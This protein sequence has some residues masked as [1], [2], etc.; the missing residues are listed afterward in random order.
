M[1][2]NYEARRRGLRKLQLITDA[3]RTCPDVVI[4]LGEDL[5][6]FRDASKVLYKFLES[7]TWNKKVER[8]GFDEVFMD[9][10]DIIHYNQALLNPNDL[11]NSFFQ[12]VKDDPTQGF[13]FDATCLSGQTYPDLSSVNPSPSSDE[14]H[15]Y[16]RLI[17]GSHLACHLRHRLEE[18]KG[19]TATVGISTTK[20]VAKLV[21]NVHKPKDQTTLLPPYEKASD[22]E[23][24]E[25][26][27]TS[28]IDAHDIGKIPGIGFKR[29]HL[30]RNHILSRPAAFDEGL[31][32]GGTKENITVRDVRLFNG[33]GPELLEKI[34]GG[35]PGAEKGIG[36]KIWNLINGIDNTEV[37]DVKTVPSQISV[38]DSYIKL[39]TFPQVVN[40]L[41][42]LV[43]SL[44]KRMHMDLVEEDEEEI[45][46]K[47][48]SRTE[49]KTMRKWIAHPKTLR[50][51]TRPRPPMNPD[52]TRPRTFNRISRSAPLPSFVFNL[53]CPIETLVTK[54]INESLLPMFRKLHPEKMGWNLSL[55][56]VCVA[57]M[58]EVAGDGKA[59]V[60]DIGLM[61][62]RQEHM[63]KEWRV[64]D[65]N[66]PPDGD[67]V[68]VDDLSRENNN[69]LE[70]EDAPTIGAETNKTLLEPDTRDGHSGKGDNA[71]A[72]L[73]AGDEAI[74]S[75]D[76]PLI[77]SHR[78]FNTPTTTGS[79]DQLFLMQTQKSGSDDDEEEVTGD[80]E[81]ASEGM[82]CTICGSFMPAFA[83]VAHERFHEIVG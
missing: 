66:V 36:G 61:F 19:Y 44:I 58:V 54:L 17:I 42:V 56:N 71:R 34:L 48:G 11:S 35:K 26:N 74:T 31:I 24:I 12:L 38:E 46:I 49:N 7:F 9:V 79:E 8:L 40:E 70:D 77:A 33:M 18:E 82:R 80:D 50:L 53:Q 3:K 63:L 51:S 52:G 15:L 59:G 83:M 32:Y 72:S 25:S 29:A 39:D 68:K 13:A 23:G 76:S 6:R 2:C 28:F 81:N 64:V 47:E 45:E 75:L 14:R 78:P 27:I 10:T 69:E 65:R 21:G 60:R 55:V 37:K 5:T 43:T 62:K 30:I 20:L 41:R 4:V 67:G 57:N 1:T 73:S 16:T 22:Q